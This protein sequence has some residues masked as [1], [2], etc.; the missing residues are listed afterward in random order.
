MGSSKIEFWFVGLTLIALLGQ[1]S[2]NPIDTFLDPLGWFSDSSSSDSSADASAASNANSNSVDDKDGKGLSASLDAANANSFAV[3]KNLHIPDITGKTDGLDANLALAGSDSFSLSKGIDKTKKKDHVIVL[4][5]SR[6]GD[7]PVVIE[8]L[9]AFARPGPPPPQ[10]IYMHGPPPPPRPMPV[11]YHRG[12]HYQHEQ[13]HN[14]HDI[15]SRPA[16]HY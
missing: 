15:G 14:V 4:P 8:E 1:S 9:P 13:P 3:G 16:Q 12:D 11:N 10:P 7:A 5:S 2:S 6:R